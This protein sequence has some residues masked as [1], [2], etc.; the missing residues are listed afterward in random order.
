MVICSKQDADLHMAHMMP[1]PLSVSCFSKI[2]IGFTFV[3]PAHPGS[4]GQ[5]TAKRVHVM[6]FWG[7]VCNFTHQNKKMPT[8]SQSVFWHVAYRGLQKMSL[9][10]TVRYMYIAATSNKISRL[11]CHMRH[12]WMS[13]TGSEYTVSRRSR[14]A[15][16]ARV[17]RLHR[18]NVTGRNCYI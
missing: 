9:A 15:T 2:Q 4:P 10:V 1:L 16:V 6:H 14:V 8:C 7:V 3:V 12:S 18:K 5:R 13:G 11:N 17:G